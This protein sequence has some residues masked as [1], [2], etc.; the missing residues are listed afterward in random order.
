MGRYGGLH[1][2]RRRLHAEEIARTDVPDTG[3]RGLSFAGLCHGISPTIVCDPGPGVSQSDD[4]SDLTPMVNASSL[5]SLGQTIDD[6]IL[7]GIY[8]FW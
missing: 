1:A 4:I 7:S 8:F 3:R 6:P 5:C 2:A